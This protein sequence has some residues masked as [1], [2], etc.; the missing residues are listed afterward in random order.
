[1]FPFQAPETSRMQAIPLSLVVEIGSVWDDTAVLQ[2]HLEKTSRI[3]AKCDVRIYP[4]E[5]T[6]VRVTPA[7]E[8]LMRV[9]N[10]YAGAPELGFLNDPALPTQRPLGLLF[11]HRPYYQDAG[12]FSQTSV[13]GLSRLGIDHG[14]LE[15][16][17]FVTEKY[18][19]DPV[20]RGYTATFSTFAHELVH[21]IG[22]ITGHNMLVGNLMTSSDARGAHSGDLTEEQCQAIRRYHPNI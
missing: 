20:T 16:L 17:F 18:E 1:M 8:V 12:A 13:S 4:V 5:L 10:P 22:D 11:G 3:L 19:R 21:V 14:P 6:R 7:A 2:K 9:S 15:D